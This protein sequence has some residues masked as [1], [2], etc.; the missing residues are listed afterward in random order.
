MPL[1]PPRSRG[2]QLGNLNALKHGFYTRRLKKRDLTGVEATDVKTLIEEIALV[3]VFTRRL[4]ESLDPSADAYELASVLRILCVAL[5]SITNAMKAQH[6]LTVND[7]GQEDELNIAIREFWSEIQ[8]R[9]SSAGQSSS[10]AAL[11]PPADD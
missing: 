10:E 6:W 7:A 1:S 2:G 5:K 4:I 11:I 9:Q 8:S 3:R